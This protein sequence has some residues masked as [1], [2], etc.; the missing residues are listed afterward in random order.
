MVRLVK[1][2]LAADRMLSARFS[3][4]AGG[5][6]DPVSFVVAEIGIGFGEGRD[7]AAGLQDREDLFGGVLNIHGPRRPPLQC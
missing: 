5:R 6:C 7:L 2:D 1:T 4:R 3:R